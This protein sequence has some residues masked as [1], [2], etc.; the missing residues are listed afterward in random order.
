[1][2]PNLDLSEI[3]LQIWIDGK[4]SLWSEESKIYKPKIVELSYTVM[5]DTRVELSSVITK[6]DLGEFS[7]PPTKQEIWNKIQ[8]LN[9][10]FIFDG[11]FQYYIPNEFNQ[12]ENKVILT[13]PL[14]EYSKFYKP[15]SINV[16]YSFIE[17]RKKIADDLLTTDLGEFNKIPN[18]KE[19]LER[20]R[21]LNPN[22]NL[23]FH[24]EFLVNINNNGKGI[25][26]L[27]L[28]PDTSL[29]YQS[30]FVNFNFVFK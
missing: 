25:I 24:P 7:K 1:L 17:N 29:I 9:P 12:K 13:I 11:S 2:N 3:I 15:G 26:H 23:D 28:Y 4:F 6:T 19:I 16:K 14:A 5:N 18:D 20:I 30:E 22:L 8:Q 10:K 21:E 27:A